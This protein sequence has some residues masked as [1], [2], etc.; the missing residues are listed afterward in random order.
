MLFAEVAATSAAVAATSGR[1][2][3][4]ELLA[5]TLR[6]F[7]PEEAE[8]GA[9]FLAGELRQRSTGV[10]WASLQDLPPAAEV[11]TL[12]VGQVAATVD[13]L[14]AISGTGSQARRKEEAHRLFAAATEPEQRLLRGLFTGEVRQGA[15][16]GILTDAVGQAAEVP[17]ALVRRALLLSGDLAIVAAAALR[18]G[19]QALDEFTLSV[20]RPLAPMLAQ[21]A[22][23]VDE[24][25]AITGVPAMADVKLDGVRIQ[26][27][28]SGDQVAIFSRSLDDLTSRLPEIVAAVRSLPARDLVLDGEALALDEAGRPHPFQIT[29]SRAATRSGAPGGLVASFFDLLH[30]DGEDFLDEPG[31]RRW[32]ALAGIVP[33]DQLI[34]RRTVTSI[35]EANAAF[36]AAIAAGHE[37]LVI[38]AVDAPYDVG[39]RGGA[40]VKVKPRHTLDLVVLAV[41]WGSGRRKGWLS[42]IHLGARDPATGELVMLGKTFKGMTDEMLEWQTTE[43]LAREVSRDG[44]IVYVRP[45]LVV[46]IAFNDVQHSPHYPG[47]V[48]LRFARVKGY[49]PDKKAADADTID[50][51]RAFLPR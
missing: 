50:A 14:A 46:E 13:R 42:N 7:S 22:S 3:K 18:G 51:V 31:H 25:L 27:H 38:K 43:L 6:G 9:A 21:A 15:L 32:A 28:R 5:A 35:E 33:P 2:A 24:A 40:W 4:I 45:E 44:H 37:G 30:A 12:T 36:D 34:G 47:G 10:G 19:A 23:S 26:V 49:R 17:S 11:A 29:A 20:G 48:A 41:E 39:R 16:A 8:P 1:K